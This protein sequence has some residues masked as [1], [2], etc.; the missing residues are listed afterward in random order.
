MKNM[1]YGGVYGSVKY[2]KDD[3]CFYG[4]IKGISDLI[5]Y[6]GQ[7][8]DELYEEFKIAVDMW[9]KDRVKL[10]SER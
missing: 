7:T 1:R 10:D 6:E 9:H 4:R 3:K 2:L 8:K 5:T